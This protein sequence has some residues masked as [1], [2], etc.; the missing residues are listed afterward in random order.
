M[1]EESF[2]IDTR[3]KELFRTLPKNIYYD[4]KHP[5]FIVTPRRR[6]PYLKTIPMARE[7]FAS[8]NRI[9]RKLKKS[10]SLRNLQVTWLNR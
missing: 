7:L 1:V 3:S 5:K 9:K 10:Q 4:F 2:A 6:I 8:H